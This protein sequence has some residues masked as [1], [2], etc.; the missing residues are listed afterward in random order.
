MSEAH[1]VSR[2]P[3]K[4]M[5]NVTLDLMLAAETHEDAMEFA[6]DLLTRAAD[7]PGYLGGSSCV[8]KEP[9]VEDD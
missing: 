1:N 6:A 5:W 2:V 4:P 9:V 3:E 7:D 8:P